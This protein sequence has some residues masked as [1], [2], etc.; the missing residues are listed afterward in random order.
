MI[1]KIIKAMDKHIVEVKK[2]KTIEEF[3]KLLP[4]RE[5]IIKQSN[6]V[7]YHSEAT[8]FMYRCISLE[9]HILSGIKEVK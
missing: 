9:F 3:N 4:S 8:K 1:W 6:K 5:N 7:G 2:C